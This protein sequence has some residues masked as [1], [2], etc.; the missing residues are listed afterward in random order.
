MECAAVEKVAEFLEAPKPGEAEVEICAA[1]QMVEIVVAHHMVVEHVVPRQMV[2]AVVA[3]E[4]V[5][6]EV[7]PGW[8]A[9]RV[10]LWVVMPGA[11]ILWGMSVSRRKNR[12]PTMWTLGLVG[13]QPH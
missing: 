10:L 3:Q 11:L 1:R 7:G 5:D 13:I 12:R 6:A 4:T 8:K 9:H 2:D